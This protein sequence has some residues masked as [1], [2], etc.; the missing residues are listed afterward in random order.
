MR[1]GDDP[2]DELR[3]RNW[4][5]SKE[6]ERMI[7][8]TQHKRFHKKGRVFSILE[9]GPY[10]YVK[11]VEDSLSAL[12]LRRLCDELAYSPLWATRRN[13]HTDERQ[14]D[15][16][17]LYRQCRSSRRGYSAEGYSISQHDPARGT[18]S[19]TVVEET[20]LKQLEPLSESLSDDDAVFVKRTPLQWEKKP[21]ETL[22]RKK[23]LPWL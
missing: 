12:S 10:L 11:L 3:L 15:H 6:H 9:L 16:H 18:L 1:H 5:L 14:E 17:V 20:M 8:S 2:N 13:P 22:L 23:E 7:Q 21:G 19:G 4:T